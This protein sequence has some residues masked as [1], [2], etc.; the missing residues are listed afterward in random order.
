M[1]FNIRSKRPLYFAFSFDQEVNKCFKFVSKK[2]EKLLEN[3]HGNVIECLQNNLKQLEKRSSKKEEVQHLKNILKSK[4][5]IITLETIEDYLM[6]FKFKS[7]GFIAAIIER[8]EKL[9][10]E[11]NNDEWMRFYAES[12]AENEDLPYEPISLNDLEEDEKLH[13]K[14]L[15]KYF[16][17]MDE[18][19]ENEGL[20]MF[21]NICRNL[22]VPFLVASTNS[23]VVNLVSTSIMYSSRR[24]LAGIWCAA[25]PKLSN[26][27]EEEV[28]KF[29]KEEID[30][31][32]FL[33]LA[34][35]VSVSEEER[36]RQLLEFYK[37]QAIK[38]RPGVS[39]ILFNA[40]R[41]IYRS[42]N[43]KKSLTVDGLFKDVLKLIITSI[44]LRKSNAFESVKGMLANADLLSGN[45][46]DSKY[47]FS[48]D[49]KT[50]ESY[51]IDKHFFYLRNPLENM[52]NTDPFLIFQQKTSQSTFLTTMPTAR[53][54]YTFQCY[55]DE[56]EEILK[57]VCLFAETLFSPKALFND[58]FIA[59]STNFC[60]NSLDGNEL[61][62]ITLLAFLESSHYN[63]EEKEVLLNGV[64]INNFLINLL[65][66]LNNRSRGR[67]SHRENLKLLDIKDELIM[68][69]SIVPC[70]YIVNHDW[71]SALKSIFNPKDSSFKLGRY[72]RTPSS[73]EIDAEFDVIDESGNKRIGVVVCKNRETPIS[74]SDYK[75]I[76]E[77]AIKYSKI[78]KLE[79]IFDSLRPLFSDKDKF[80]EFVDNLRS[81]SAAVKS[82][83]S[84]EFLIE[85]FETPEKFE[86]VKNE[87][88]G[89][90]N[91]GNSGQFETLLKT[92]DGFKKTTP[93]FHFLICKKCAD[94]D[95]EDL[96]KT[97]PKI[98]VFRFI[99]NKENSY[100]IIPVI[101]SPRSNPDMVAF[102]LEIDVI[103]PVINDVPN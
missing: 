55:F 1:A 66:N 90:F 88:N 85:K 7:L 49:P 43:D 78:K 20:M 99:K 42:F 48:K 94:L 71:P 86:I 100:D 80:D 61:E 93:L 58:Q 28:E 39:L 38:T 103:N 67:R 82:E 35:N 92:L 70:L 102:I 16:F 33:E 4:P 57:L 9:Y 3:D 13:K 26:L 51:L 79:S 34:R 89:L 62:N 97:H 81:P 12:Q 98:N 21:R 11:E 27:T 15:E 31:K 24:D 64:S 36:M 5:V 60:N 59:R 23:R 75:E 50:T 63:Y 8:S 72:S 6:D 14:F 44:S 19:K 53:D 74:S 10:T 68:G 69:K 40:L 65:E 84:D 22:K 54:E 18:F 25:L 87:I 29:F 96:V 41:G 101:S 76:I 17:F 73:S 30:S 46:F 91:Y 56:K 32:R 83:K 77:K 2:F 37:D 52:K 47:S 45:A 95:L